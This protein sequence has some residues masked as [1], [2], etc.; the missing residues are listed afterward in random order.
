MI[1]TG[2]TTPSALARRPIWTMVPRSTM[3]GTSVRSIVIGEV[4]RGTRKASPSSNVHAAAN[5]MSSS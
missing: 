5:T 1:R 4:T 2:G 3:R